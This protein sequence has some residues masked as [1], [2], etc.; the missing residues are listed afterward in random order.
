MDSNSVIKFVI[1]ILIGLAA[2]ALAEAIW[3]T[4][5]LV[6][7]DVKKARFGIAINHW[8]RLGQFVLCTGSAVA[9]AIIL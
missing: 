5:N 2:L 6:A 3:S 8:Y 1:T 7:E 9:L 4:R